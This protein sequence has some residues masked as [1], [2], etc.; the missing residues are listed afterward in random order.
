MLSAMVGT[1]G[2]DKANR[3]PNKIYVDDSISNM[4]SAMTTMDKNNLA[5]FN[6]YLKSRYD[7][8]KGDLTA[9]QH[10]CQFSL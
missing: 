7:E 1:S 8:I 6:E 3:D 5:K 4:V 2:E 10:I 9:I